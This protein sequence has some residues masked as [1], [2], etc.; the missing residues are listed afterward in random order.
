MQNIK[1]I[2][3]NIRFV[4]L[5]CENK[6]RAKRQIVKAQQKGVKNT[7]PKFIFKLIFFNRRDVFKTPVKTF[8][9]YIIPMKP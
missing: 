6:T 5:K 9:K 4:K 8:E 2:N 3:K 7:D 1:N